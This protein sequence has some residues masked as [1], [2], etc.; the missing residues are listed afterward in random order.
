MINRRLSLK[1]LLVASG[2]LI[3]HAGASYAATVQQLQATALLRQ[4]CQACHAVGDKRFITD[5]DD[6]L[7]WDFIQNAGPSA[8]AMTWR[9]AIIKVLSWPSD[10]APP[11]GVPMEPNRDWMPKG[12]KRLDFATA[13]CEGQS[14]R[15]FIL[16]HL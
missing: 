2:S 1:I 12:G 16:E 13:M 3:L 4:Y 14:A 10:K 11:F 9:E 7:V 8:S 15:T 6:G 5:E